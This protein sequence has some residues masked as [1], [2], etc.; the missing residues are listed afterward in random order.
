MSPRDNDE[1]TVNIIP[2]VMKHFTVT[3]FRAK[4]ALFV[5]WWMLLHSNYVLSFQSFHDFASARTSIRNTCIVPV[6]KGR[7]TT[8]HQSSFSNL[9][10]TDW[11]LMSEERRAAAISSR[12]AITHP[13]SLS[14]LS[15]IKFLVASAKGEAHLYLNL[16]REKHGD[17]FIIWNK[18]VT[19]NDKTAIRDVLETYNLP[20]PELVLRG[21]R[22]FFG[23][24]SILAAPWEEWK[25]QRRMSNAALAEASIGAL[26]PRLVEG[27][28]PL[29]NLLEQAAAT[30]RVVEMDRVFQAAT[31]DFICLVIFGKSFGIGKGLLLSLSATSSSGQEEEEEELNMFTAMDLMKAESQRQMVFP[32]WILNLFGPSKK[33]MEAKQ[34]VDSFLE[35]CI[36][37]RIEMEGEE[38]QQITDLMNVLLDSYEKGTIT[39]EEVKGQ[40]LT[41]LFAGQDTTAHTLAWMLYE[42]SQNSELQEKLAHETKEA[43]PDRASFA[44]SAVLQS[45]QLDLLDRSF[46]EALRKY[47]AAASGTIRVVGETPIIVGDSNL[48]LPPGASITIA[49]YVLHRNQ[50][51]WPD[52]EHFDPDRFL[53]EMVKNRDPMTFQA[54]SGGPRNCVGSR[55]ARIIALT[56][57]STLLRRFRVKCVEEKLPPKQFAALTMKPKHGIRFVFEPRV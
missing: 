2:S 36:V 45:N 26:E 51:Y 20:K 48:E 33:V 18:Y 32:E 4:N 9:N 17:A 43:L 15:G 22:F 53:P 52:P 39:R 23:K 14:F 28:T 31:T 30:G 54:F 13:K 1:Y 24:G 41:F 29:L 46:S 34:Y 10:N 50:K 35:E 7:L 42:I 3:S 6:G 38:R 25:I 12:N 44:N 37:E 57:M 11:S 40:L 8:L 49:P 19:I 27:I 5:L 21:Y 55:L 56:T 47:P 16:L